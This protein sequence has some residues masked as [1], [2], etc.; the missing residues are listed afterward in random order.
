MWNS[1][2]TNYQHLNGEAVQL[3]QSEIE[4]FA[5]YHC[6]ALTD[7]GDWMSYP[8]QDKVGFVC[9]YAPQPEGKFRVCLPLQHQV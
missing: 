8:C 2:L 5:E 3:N 7:H 1:S 6:I 4:F 9:L